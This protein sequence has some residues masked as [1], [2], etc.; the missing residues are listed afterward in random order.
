MI[1]VKRLWPIYISGVV[2][3]IFDKKPLFPG[4]GLANYTGYI[5]TNYLKGY[6]KVVGIY[7]N[8]LEHP[9]S[10]A[11]VHDYYDRTFC[12]IRLLYTPP[13]Y[14]GKGYAANLIKEISEN[15]KATVV[16]SD[17]GLKDFYVRS[18]FDKWFSSNDNSGDLIGA[19][20]NFKLKRIS[21]LPSYPMF[22]SSLI[23]DGIK[24]DFRQYIAMKDNYEKSIK[25]FNSFYGI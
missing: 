21:G 9:L 18:G 20:N 7:S 8:D 19:Y 5:K 14:R 1:E 22:N 4:E 11:V 6:A 25:K 3:N 15:Q 10:M 12:R 23:I 17:K 13:M 24:S 16:I 2:S